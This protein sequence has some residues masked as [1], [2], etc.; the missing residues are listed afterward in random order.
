MSL[1]NFQ[2]LQIFILDDKYSVFWQVPLLTAHTPTKP[3][4]SFHT[5]ALL[6]IIFRKYACLCIFLHSDIVSNSWSE[7]ISNAFVSDW[8]NLLN[9]V[10]MT[11]LIWSWWWLWSTGSDH[12]V[13]WSWSADVTIC[14]Q[15]LVILL[16][17][18][19]SDHIGSADIIVCGK[20]VTYLISRYYL[21]CIFQLWIGSRGPWCMRRSPW[22]IRCK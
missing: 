5:V 8:N 14:G 15:H 11:K 22:V 1:F 18:P 2:E 20:G 7:L 10:D 9:F 3:S 19:L 4:C 17:W 16:W 12:S 13:I 21:W 6:K